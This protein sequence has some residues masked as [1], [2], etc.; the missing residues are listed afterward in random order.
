MNTAPIRNVILVLAALMLTASVITWIMIPATLTVATVRVVG[1]S[2]TG[3]VRYLNTDSIWKNGLTCSGKPFTISRRIPNALILINK[4][5]LIPN[6]TELLLIQGHPDSIRIK[7]ETQYKTGLNPISRITN[8]QKALA[9]KKCTE[10]LLDETRNFLQDNKNLYG[11]SIS[12]TTLTDTFLIS[13]RFLS[14]RYPSVDMIYSRIDGIRKYI[15]TSGAAETS[16]PML[17][18]RKNDDGKLMVMI[19]IATTRALKDSAMFTTRR[20]AQYKN[21]TLT[22][23]VRGGNESVEKAISAMQ[24]YMDDYRV[25]NPTTYFELLITDRRK[26][27]DPAKWLTRIY[28]PI[29]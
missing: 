21:R 28:Y 17:N 26:E 15:A 20:L 12:R 13:T 10:D 27:K 19:G 22:T 23:E 1:T 2:M 24:K 18:V 29:V 16:Q 8:Y 25:T 4:S 7:W 9:F 6:P 14:Q 3:A 11:F 5:P